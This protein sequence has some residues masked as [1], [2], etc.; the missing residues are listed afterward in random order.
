MS[1]IL[2]IVNTSGAVLE[3]VPFPVSGDMAIGQTVQI[4]VSRADIDKDADRG[5]TPW[6]ELEALRRAGDISMAWSG[7][8]LSPET[9]P[10][11]AL[12]WGE[13]GGA[14]TDSRVILVRKE[15]YTTEENAEGSI[16]YPFD[17]IQDAVDFV[18]ANMAP[19]LTAPVTID[20]GPGVFAENV[21]V[22]GVAFAG[23]LFR[24][25]GEQIT[26][27]QPAAGRGLVVTNSTVAGLALYYAGTYADLVND[28]TTG[29]SSCYLKD[30]S[31]VGVGAGIP[32]FECLGVMGDAAADQ[33][34][35]LTDGVHLLGGVRLIPGAG[36]NALHVRNAGALT[37]HEG[38][39]IVGNT[40]VRQV[41][42]FREHHGRFGGTFTIGFDVADLQGYFDGGFVANQFDEG[43]FTGKA[44]FDTGANSTLHRPHFVGE[45]EINGTASLVGQGV[46]VGGALDV[47]GTGSF[48]AL[49][50]YV[51]GDAD[52]EAGAFLV[53]RKLAI[54]GDLTIVAGAGTVS[55][56]ASSVFGT[57]TDAGNKLPSNWFDGP[58]DA[59]DTA[60][61]LPAIGFLDNAVAVGITAAGGVDIPVNGR[62]LLQGQT[63]ASVTI[64]ATLDI[65][66][67][68]PGTSGND[69]SVE[70]IDSDIGGLVLAWAANTLT[71]DV[72]GAASTEDQIATAINT[73]ASS[74]V[75]TIIRANSGGGA[76]PGVTAVVPLTG[77]TGRGFSASIN[78]VNIPILHDNG[79]ATSVANLTE[80]LCT[81]NPPDLTGVVPAMA[82][83]DDVCL[84]I[85]SNG[86]TLP[87][88]SST[89]V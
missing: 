42:A 65:I 1:C 66:A 28:T 29:P 31:I 88:I 59:R 77:G 49:D 16:R 54:Y 72:G 86:I 68:I 27:I 60:L 19:S 70:I 75:A 37:V 51:E 48:S 20:I 85:V 36:G 89:L 11:D 34:D 79:A 53:G 4:G 32:A 57:I 23:V 63:F 10:I 7:D 52:F 83:H 30:L 22:C 25:A 69:Y 55:L 44:T 6:R 71:I 41:A 47:N 18:I 9:D 38:N 67:C 35:F 12:T 24:G 80:V 84:L 5:N 50:S 46:F 43:R 40:L 82:A 64:G 17:N 14:G 33:T 56:F 76:A 81:L 8:P 58:R 3:D 45:L 13:G 15:G 73:V 21:V 26:I 74:P 39:N 2:T 87:P 62:Y 61:Q 78:G